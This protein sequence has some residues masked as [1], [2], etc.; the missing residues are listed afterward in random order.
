MKIRQKVWNLTSKL[1]P[2]ILRKMYGMNLGENVIISYKANLDKSINPKGIYIGD[3]T[4]ILANATIL[5]HDYCRGTNKK[6]KRFNTFIGNNCVIGIN[7]I[8]MPG[9]TI[10]NEVIVGSGSVVTKD[11]PNNCIVAG[12][13]AK[14]I[15]Q[16]IRIDN[17][18]QIIN[19]N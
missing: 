12:N 5:A 18:G 6:G 7:C 2:M 13:P 19:N 14:V 9:V 15:K 1:Y 11:V 4:W 10:G 16:G 3:N 17:Y 8:I